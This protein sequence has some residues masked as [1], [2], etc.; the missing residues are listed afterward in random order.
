MNIEVEKVYKCIISHWSPKVDIKHEVLLKR[1]DEDDCD[2]RFVEDGSELS[3]DW[4]VESY[5][6]VE[7]K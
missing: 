1:V 6:E 3:Y 7:K 5:T 2:W 4:N